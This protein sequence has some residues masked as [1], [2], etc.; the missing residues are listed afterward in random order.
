MRIDEAEE[1]GAEVEAGLFC[2]L[3][4]PLLRRK[5]RDIFFGLQAWE[6]TWQMQRLRY[7]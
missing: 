1:P 5:N 7:S 3:P 2:V 4:E 6:I